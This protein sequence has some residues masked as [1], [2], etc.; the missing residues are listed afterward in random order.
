MA[1]ARSRTLGSRDQTGVC[2]CKPVETFETT[3]PALSTLRR[4]S[5]ISASVVDI[6]N[7]GTSPS[8]NSM[9]S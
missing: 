2:Q 3:K 6:W 8:H 7:H 5:R 1:I 9:P 4:N